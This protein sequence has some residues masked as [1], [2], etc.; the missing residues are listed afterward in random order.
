MRADPDST[1]ITMFI[2]RASLTGLYVATKSA[3]GGVMELSNE[4]WHSTDDMRKLCTD[5]L[6]GWGVIM[7]RCCWHAIAA[8]LADDSR[9]RSRL[10]ITRSISLR[11][12]SFRNTYT[13][14]LRVAADRAHEYTTTSGSWTMDT[15]TNSGVQLNRYVDNTIMDV[16]IALLSSRNSNA[17]NIAFELRRD[18]SGSVHTLCLRVRKLF[19]RKGEK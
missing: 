10:H 2:F 9:S 7:S 16:F 5:T 3:G 19:L 13:S 11:N 4:C 14:G 8:A 17:E 12:A 6:S 15:C 18:R 1:S